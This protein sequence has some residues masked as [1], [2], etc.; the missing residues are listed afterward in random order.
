MSFI[1]KKA[2]A[3]YFDALIT[4]SIEEKNIKNVKK[5]GNTLILEITNNT[6]IQTPINKIFNF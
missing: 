3:S 1:V 4:H 2:V 5:T 6:Q